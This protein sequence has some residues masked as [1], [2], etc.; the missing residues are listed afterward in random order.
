MSASLDEAPWKKVETGVI[1]NPTDTGFF[2]LE[3][4]PAD[5]YKIVDG[6]F[7]FQNIE[8]PKDQEIEKSTKTNAEPKVSEKRKKKKKRK[9]TKE[10]GEKNE[11][12]ASALSSNEQTKTS[13][14]NDNDDK[15]SD[16]QEQLETTAGDYLEWDQYGLHEKILSG[17]Q[18]LEFKSPTE[19]QKACLPRAI[20]DGRDILGAAETG[21]GKT[22]AYGIP[23]LNNLLHSPPNDDD[24]L[25]ALVLAPTRELA[26]QVQKHFEQVLVSGDSPKICRVATVVG[27]MSL[28]KQERVLRQKPH[29][30]I[31]TPGRFWSLVQQGEDHLSDLA[32]SLRFLVID[33]ADRMFDQGHFPE[34]KPF[35]ELLQRSRMSSNEGTK[36]N[37]RQ[38]FLFSATLMCTREYQKKRKSRKRRRGQKSDQ[39]VS[40]LQELMQQI[41]LRGK[42][43]LCSIER[44]KSEDREETT[45]HQTIKLPKTLRMTEIMCTDKDKATYAYYFLTQ[46]RGRTLIFVNTIAVLRRLTAILLHLKVQNL[47]S[48]HANMQ[49]RQRLKHLDRFR[50]NQSAVLVATDVA[51][52]G[53]DIPEVKYVIHYGVSYC[54]YFLF[55]SL[56]IT[57]ISIERNLRSPFRSYGESF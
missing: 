39:S 57:G 35:I 49:Q 26:I 51:A 9:K 48:L 53:L 50:S 28:A 37:K 25:A 36:R 38:T 6:K 19:I 29:V 27:G 24:K 5:Q 1:D 47:G 8:K 12:E 18:K 33:E 16:R 55:L 7:T 56:T 40:P 54:I 4:V 46:H 20:R 30:L 52:R 23:M 34:L 13:A 21:S 14:S 17:L 11:N 15:E 22:L 44:E 43:A 45:V 3:E 31:A 41:G 2:M 42:P 10:S 32:S